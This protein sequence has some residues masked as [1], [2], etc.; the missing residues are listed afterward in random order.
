MLDNNTRNTINGKADTSGLGTLAYSN[1]VEK[2]QLG[3]TVISGSFINTSLIR[4]DLILAN[5]A[6]IGGFTI[7][8]TVDSTGVL[9]WRGSIVDLGRNM[10]IVL[11]GYKSPT[12][13]I[14]STIYA[15]SGNEYVYDGVIT[16]SG[17]AGRGCAIYGGINNTPQLGL[18]FP[19]HLENWAGYFNGSVNVTHFLVSKAFCYGKYISPSGDQQMDVGL[20]INWNDYDLDDVRFCVRGGI[21]VGVTSDSGTLR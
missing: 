16:I 8:N 21:I 12:K 9:S 6:Y 1:L 3:S 17:I 15:N 2:A 13:N 19:H 20:D 7:G 14:Y 10:E 11:G 5:G 4:T 18:T